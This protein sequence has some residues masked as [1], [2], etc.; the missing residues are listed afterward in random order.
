MAN[1]WYEFDVFNAPVRPFVGGGIGIAWLDLHG[2]IHDKPATTGTTFT[3]SSAMHGTKS[4]FAWQLG[5]GLN[6]E[7]APERDITLE[8]RY[9]NG[10]TLDKVR[11]H[12]YVNDINYDYQSHSLM[13]GFRAGF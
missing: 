11:I 4:G 9:F 7:I 1:A 2:I 13:V 5:A 10:P 12:D 8:Y 6:W 3:D